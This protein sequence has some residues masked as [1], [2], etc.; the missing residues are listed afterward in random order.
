MWL[1]VA[2][3]PYPQVQLGNSDNSSTDRHNTREQAVTVC[4]MLEEIGFGGDGEIF[5]IKTYVNEKP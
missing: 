1:S 5:P 2:K 3:W 4:S